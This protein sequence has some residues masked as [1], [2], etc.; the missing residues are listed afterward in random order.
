MLLI[1]AVSPIGISI[2]TWLDPAAAFL[3]RTDAIN[4]PSLSRSKDFSTRI[5]IS[6]AGLNLAVLPQAMQ[7]PSFST[8]FLICAIVRF[9]IVITSMVS[10]VPAG[11]VMAREEV[12]GMVNPKAV[13]MDTMM[14]VVLFPGSPPIQCL[15]TTNFFSQL[16]RCPDEIIAWVRKVISSLV[17]RFPAQAVIKLSLIHISE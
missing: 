2:T 10:A 11:D 7:P 17:I 4:W 16:M 1:L 8:T 14:G 15:S 13:T 9:T 6:S 12:L 5:R 3:D